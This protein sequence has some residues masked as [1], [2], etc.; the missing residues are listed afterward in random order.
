MLSSLKL[1]IAKIFA[2]SESRCLW[3]SGGSDSRLLLEVMCETGLP[4]G[5]LRF[6]DGWSREQIKAVDDVIVS[7]NLQVFSYPARSHLLVGKDEKMGLMSSYA[8]GSS[9]VMLGRDLVDGDK[10]AFDIRLE[11]ARQS[12]APINYDVHIQ[13]LRKT[14]RHWITGQKRFVKRTQET[15]GGKRHIYP[16]WNWTRKDV[17]RGL[18]AYGVSASKLIETGETHC[19]HNCLKGIQERV[20]CPK[21]NKEIDSVKFSKEANLQLIQG[22]MGWSQ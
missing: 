14:D 21:E 17:A 10:C 13:G 20:F 3:L 6:T 4:F 1:A 9:S 15:V 7:K 22:M 18:K 16:L 12:N 11:K 19:C 5:I 2:E 8:V